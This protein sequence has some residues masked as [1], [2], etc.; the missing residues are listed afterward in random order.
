MTEKAR[1]EP[2]GGAAPQG[3]DQ[4]FASP[5]DLSELSL[6]ITDIAEKSRHLVT[7]S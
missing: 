4:A 2:G 3:S 7:E 1:D 5:P 6:Q